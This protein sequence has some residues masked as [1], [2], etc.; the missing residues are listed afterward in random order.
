MTYD[1][2]VVDRT[3]NS[4]VTDRSTY[5]LP[6]GQQGVSCPSKTISHVISG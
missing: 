5:R 3:V 4:W 2:G 1:I 6:F